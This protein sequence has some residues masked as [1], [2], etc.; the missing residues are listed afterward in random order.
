MIE[1]GTTDELIEHLFTLT[2][3]AS[4][5]VEVGACLAEFSRRVAA[6]RPLSDVIALEANPYNWRAY[7]ESMP[8]GVDYINAAACDVDGPVEFRIMSVVKGAHLNQ[9]AGNNSLR[10]R[11]DDGIEYE[12]AEVP[13]LRVD[14]LLSDRGLTGQP[15]VLWV[16]V[17]GAQDTV[18]AGATRALGDC[19]A[20]M[21]E[22]EEH[23]YWTGQRLA[24]DVD[25]ILRA[26]G[27]VA[28]ARDREFP[29]QHNRLYVRA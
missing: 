19:V 6:E 22:V 5:F 28:I 14:T 9:V 8:S 13:G 21:I 29:L 27:M 26:L 24:D 1:Y 15:C 4:V 10:T 7:A 3:G 17:E 2:D 11:V 23:R 12:V 20:L 16:D 25:E 18:I